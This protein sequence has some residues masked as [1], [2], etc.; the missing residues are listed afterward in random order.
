MARLS[1]DKREIVRRGYDQVGAGYHAAR[2]VDG[3]DVGLLPELHRRIRP[4]ARILDV[5]CGT[6][7]PIARELADLGH[8]VVGVDLSMVQL[9][10]AK[11]HVPRLRGV[12]AEMTELPIGT[13]AFD[14]L[15]SF[16]AVIHVPRDD[17]GAVFREFRRVLRTEG[18][19]LLCIGT[20]DNPEDHDTDSWLGTPM[21]WSHFD[22]ETTTAIITGAGWRVDTS[23]QVPD[24]MGH[25]THRF[26]LARAK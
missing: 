14:A 18:S 3:R 12:A 19:A 16:Y 2:P 17:H 23:W 1:D 25:G 15:V 8:E 9:V 13:G 5:G 11:S 20:D 6:G 22:A 21:Y 10:L 4:G 24:P 26:V 7:V